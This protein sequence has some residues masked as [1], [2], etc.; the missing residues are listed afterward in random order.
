M[1]ILHQFMAHHH[2]QPGA[3]A[4][5]LRGPPTLEMPMLFKRTFLEGI[6]EGRITLAFRRWRRPSLCP[7]S[8]LRTPAGLI[9]IRNIAAVEAAAI[10]DADA[11]AAGYPDRTALLAALAD[12]PA[13]DL[14]RIGLRFAG[15]DPRIALRA[16]AAFDAAEVAL[17]RGRLARLDRASRHGPWTAAVLRL[18]EERPGVRAAELAAALGRDTAAFKRDVRKLKEL[19]LTESLDVGYRLLPRGTRLRQAP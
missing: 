14:Y 4:P 3:S 18:L 15:A 12:A 9:E 7:G 5:V 10:G 8:R 1:S 17:L 11:R 2:R 16:D 6:A 19:G 13:G